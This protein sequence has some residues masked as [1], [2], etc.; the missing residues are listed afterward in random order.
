MESPRY[1]PEIESPRH[2]PSDLLH[3]EIPSKSSSTLVDDHDYANGGSPNYYSDEE[4]IEVYPS[5]T[6]L[7]DGVSP[8]H[9]TESGMSEMPFDER[10]SYEREKKKNKKQKKDDINDDDSNGSGETKSAKKPCAFSFSNKTKK[11]KSSKKRFDEN[12]AESV[13][14]GTSKTKDNN[15]K[16]TRSP[17][18]PLWTWFTEDILHA[19]IIR[20]VVWLSTTSA[21]YPYTTIGALS[22]ASIALLAIGFF[23]NF[24]LVLDTDQIFTPMNSL[25]MKHY[26]WLMED[27]G[28]N[29]IRPL[30]LI[31]HAHGANVLGK[32]S[33]DKLFDAID[34]VRE[35]PGYDDLCQ[36]GSYKS[37]DNIHTCRILSATRFW[38]HDRTKFEQNITNDED[39]AMMLSRSLYPNSQT[40]V[41]RE[42]ILG[43]YEMS[44]STTVYQANGESFVQQNITEHLPQVHFVQSLFVR[45]ELPDV[46]ADADEFEARAWEALAELKQTWEDD[47]TAFLETGHAPQSEPSVSVST[48]TSNGDAD[49]NL[50]AQ[51]LN[52]ELDFLSIFAY[53]IE[54]QRALIRDLPLVGGI[55]LVLMIF[56]TL[57][58]MKPHKVY[59]RSMLGCA[60][61]ATIGITL[62]FSYGLVWCIGIPFTNIAQIL[63]FM[64]MGVGVSSRAS[65]QGVLLI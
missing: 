9:T 2:D 15:S 23:T 29:N 14:R 57:V 17:I 63:P 20:T 11:S 30:I 51:Y 48:N 31:L 64:V 19:S 1:D 12:A 5:M 52:L 37:Y 36:R 34:A 38:N 42:L 65:D 62:M 44:S 25:P 18:C 32:H 4:H 55:I 43:N 56:T 40:P 8:C 47:N 24:T 58:F 45:F 41:F 59:S 33:L 21:R 22:L 50:P 60:S 39:A 53:K 27:S 49:N 13:F 16:T 61:L 28:F 7:M 46:G 10:G 3:L 26:E 54:N 35:T 6:N